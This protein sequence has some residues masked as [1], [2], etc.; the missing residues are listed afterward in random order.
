[1]REMRGGRTFVV[2]FWVVVPLVQKGG[3]LVVGGWGF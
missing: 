3:G 1:M 2:M